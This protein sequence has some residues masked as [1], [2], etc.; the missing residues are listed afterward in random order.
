MFMTV[1]YFNSPTSILF[2]IYSYFELYFWVI[3][4]VFLSLNL[5]WELFFIL[6]ILNT[7]KCAVYKLSQPVLN[8]YL[9]CIKPLQLK[10]IMVFF[11]LH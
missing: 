9:G 11:A 3:C 7:V 10:Y 5:I 4:V 2:W 6:T 1:T 8:K